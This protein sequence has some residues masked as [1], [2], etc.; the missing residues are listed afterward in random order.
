MCSCN[1]TH[2]ESIETLHWCHMSIMASQ[3]THN[4][5]VF[6]T[7]FKDNIREN[8]KV[9]HSSPSWGESTDNWWILVTKGQ[10]YGKLFHIMMSS[11]R[12][13]C[14]KNIISYLHT[15]VK[16]CFSHGD[17]L[18]VISH[19]Y[20]SAFEFLHDQHVCLLN[21]QQLIYMISIITL[22]ILQT[23]FLTW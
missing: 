5:T 21:M 22:T 15:G 11:F 8:I 14:Y 17:H 10:L 12:W 20:M 9:P 23:S 16:M 1:F 6:A 19:V 4:S 2:A 18:I 13:V 7:A 3:I